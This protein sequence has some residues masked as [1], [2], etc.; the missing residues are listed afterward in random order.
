MDDPHSRYQD[1]SAQSLAADDATGWFDRLYAEADAGRAV[2]PW[3]RGAPA[4]LLAEWLSRRQITGVDRT[5]LV[6]G[7]GGGHDAELIAGLGFDVTAFDVSAT[8]VLAVTRRYPDSKVN[9]VAADLF[10]PPASW[11]RAF[12]LVVEVR[13]VQSLPE[14]LHLAAIDHIGQFV[15][16]G[17]GRLLVIAHA[18][19]ATEPL[20]DTPPWPLTRA[21]IDAF[22]RSGLHPVE[23]EPIT[24]APGRH[25][26]RAEFVHP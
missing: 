22:A 17:E 6:V 5:A 2:V 20:D 4:P 19:D 24:L 7:F 25:D 10:D 21:E 16:G 14:H 26:W 1:L 11:H 8:A 12:D 13:T 15:A 3:D 18:R 9:Y 23:I